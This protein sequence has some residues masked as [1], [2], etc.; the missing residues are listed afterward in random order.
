MARWLAPK[1][2]GPQRWV[3]HDR[4]GE[5]LERAA[6]DAPG[7][8]WDGSIVTVETRQSD[9]TR[10][11]AQDLAGADLVTA[12]ALLD[13]LT[14]DDLRAIAAACAGRPALFTISV[15]GR[16]TISP[17]DPLDARIAAAFDDH[18][19]RRVGEHGRLGPDA[20]EAAVAAF[21]ACGVSTTVLPSPWRLG[22]DDADLIGQWMLGWIAAAC[23]HEPALARPARAYAHR[24]LAEA[25][26]GKLS[27]VVHHED[28]L[29][30]CG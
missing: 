5:L 29:A 23:E 2:P 15:V 12:S 20:V 10:L 22:A 8:A 26:A 13:M 16:V 30:G 27:V 1:L 11:T 19:R 17:A 14:A 9:I 28:L 6:I 21:A 7:K 18:Q 25:A 24:R 4:D 3:L